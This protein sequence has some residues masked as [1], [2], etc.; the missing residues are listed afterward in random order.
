[1]KFLFHRHCSCKRM[2]PNCG[3]FVVVAHFYLQYASIHYIAVGKEKG[4]QFL[5]VQCRA[6]DVFVPFRIVLGDDTEDAS[7]N[8]DGRFVDNRP[9]NRIERDSRAYL[10]KAKGAHHVPGGHLP[11]IFIPYDAIRTFRV[12]IPQDEIQS[13]LSFPR[14]GGPVI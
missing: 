8:G 7:F 11:A 1:M 4:V 12:E 6:F 9:S 5:P 10:V 14:R 3:L 13:F 2:R